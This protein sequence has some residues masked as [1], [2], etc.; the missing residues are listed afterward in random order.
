MPENSKAP[1]LE[2]L[3]QTDSAKTVELTSAAGCVRMIPFSG[4]AEG[5]L[6]HGI[7][8]PCCVDTQ[9]TNAA[10]VRHMSARYMLTGTDSTGA[11]CHIYVAN[12]A[13]FTDGVRPRPWHSVPSFLTD[14]SALAPILHRNAFVGEGIREEDGLHIRFYEVS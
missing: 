8:E 10:D 2:L 9:I 3:I 13:W 12:E 11:L 14:S 1:I 6:F 4:T 7:I 5:P